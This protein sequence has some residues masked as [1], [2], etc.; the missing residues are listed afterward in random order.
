MVVNYQGGDNLYKL[1]N[2]GGIVF[3]CREV[4]FLIEITANG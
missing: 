3:S 1:Q 2:I 4:F